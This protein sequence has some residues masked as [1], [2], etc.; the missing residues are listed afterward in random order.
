MFRCRCLRRFYKT[1]E[2]AREDTIVLDSYDEA[3]DTA[4]VHYDIT[5][6]TMDAARVQC[7]RR[8]DSKYI[9]VTA[10]QQRCGRGTSN[11]SWLSPLGNV[12]LTVCVRKDL[13]GT[14]IAFLPLDT[15]VA[16]VEGVL[17]SLPENIRTPDP[18]LKGRLPAAPGAAPMQV[19]VKWP[20][21]VLLGGS[22]IS[23]NLIEDGGSHMLIG[24]GINVKV[25]PQ[26]AD[27][28]RAAESL[29][30]A[31]AHPESAPEVAESVASHLIDRLQQP[32]AKE[33]VQHYERLIDWAEPVRERLEGGG[34]GPPLRAIRLTEWGHLVVQG[35]DG[36][37][38]SLCT[39]YLF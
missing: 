5:N 38:R 4:R 36:E 7:A 18:R 22:K 35:E 1:M 31:G 26:V 10:S 30:S 39:T 21:D 13:L 11:R 29:K 3:R 20:N 17:D 15:G 8:S 2:P 6:S 37:E 25:R 9:V 16:V 28:G 32:L 24:I 23:G 33:V 19:C 14:R 27:G 34:R 12:Y